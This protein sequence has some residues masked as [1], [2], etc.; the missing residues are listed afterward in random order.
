MSKVTTEDDIS[1]LVRTVCSDGQLMLF[2]ER[3]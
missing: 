3:L 2:I 1:G